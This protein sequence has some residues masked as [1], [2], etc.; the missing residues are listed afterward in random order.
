MKKTLTTL[1]LAAVASWHRAA[2]AAATLSLLLATPAGATQATAL[3]DQ[4]KIIVLITSIDST[5]HSSLAST[6]ARLVVAG[7]VNLAEAA[8]P[9]GAIGAQAYRSEVS[10]TRA[11]HLTAGPAYTIQR[12]GFVEA[13][14]GNGARLRGWSFSGRNASAESGEWATFRW[15]LQDRAWHERASHLSGTVLAIAVL[16]GS[17]ASAAEL[18]AIFNATVAAETAKL[19][20]AEAARVEREAAARNARQWEPPFNPNMY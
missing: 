8:S 11:L 10:P 7:V 1:R 20:A 3:K 2:V 17:E 16:R 12:V 13:P 4:Q 14:G 5:K 9:V 18:D 19:K 15:D 6:V